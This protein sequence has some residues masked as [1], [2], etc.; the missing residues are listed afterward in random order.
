MIKSYFKAGGDDFKNFMVYTLLVYN[1]TFFSS[2]AQ[3]NYFTPSQPIKPKNNIDYRVTHTEPAANGENIGRKNNPPAPPHV[4]T[5]ILKYFTR[6]NT[7]DI[8]RTKEIIKLFQNF[9]AKYTFYNNQQDSAVR[10]FFTTIFDDSSF[11]ELD[12]I[13]SITEPLIS[14]IERNNSGTLIGTLETTDLLSTI[15]FTDVDCGVLNK[16]NYEKDTEGQN[17]P[18]NKEYD[19]NNKNCTGLNKMISI[20]KSAIYENKKGIIDSIHDSPYRTKDYSIKDIDNKILETIDENDFQKRIST[21]VED[22]ITG[23]ST[24]NLSKYNDECSSQPLEQGG[25]RKYKSKTYKK[26]TKN[27]VTLKK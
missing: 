17:L 3:L 18:E 27:N 6:I 21:T 26:R 4:F 15:G 10:S 5:N 12:N 16:R 7:T 8:N 11:D 20:F 22:I 19:E 1:T 9:L 13:L 14:F 25:K 2:P 24:K 23:S